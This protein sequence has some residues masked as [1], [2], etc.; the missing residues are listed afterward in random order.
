MNLSIAYA[1]ATP[2]CAHQSAYWMH[3]VC[4]VSLIVGVS[5][6]L[7]AWRTHTASTR[8][9]ESTGHVRGFVG[10]LAVPSGAFFTLVVG[11][12]WLCVWLLSPCV[13]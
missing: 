7:G 4:V 9:Q 10:R 12:Q 11:M 3:V 6:T 13:A 8:P 2:A 5:V 1:L